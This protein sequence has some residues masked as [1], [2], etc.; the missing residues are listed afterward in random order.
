MKTLNQ[1]I[2]AYTKHLQQGDLQVAYKGILDYMSKL[3]SHFVSKYPNYEI[4]GNI[5]QGYMDMSYFSINTKQLKDKGLKIAIVYLHEKGSFEIWLSARNRAILKKY[6]TILNSTALESVPVFHDADNED[7]AIECTLTAEPDFDK[8]G[9]LTEIIE[10]STE[11]FIS[12][13]TRHL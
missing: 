2:S 8:Q 12:V 6:K 9:V 10:G 3:R 1:L 11:E 5:Y 4:S 7:A 13:I